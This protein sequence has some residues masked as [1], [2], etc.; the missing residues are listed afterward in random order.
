M[1]YDNLIKSWHKKAQAEDDY[2]IKFVFEYLAFI[3]YLNKTN[4]DN[5]T[6]RKL[7]Q[8]LKRSEEIKNTFIGVVDTGTIKNLIRT[9]RDRAIENVTNPDDKWWD[10]DSD[11]CPR[12]QSGDDGKIKNEKDFKNIIEFVYRARNNLFHGK[13]GPEIERD[14]IIVRHG[15]EILKPL[16]EILTGKSQ[17][18]NEATNS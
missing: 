17:V 15:F 2:F 5:K 8:E 10:C 9:L 3:A 16:M 13:K 1:N 14:F 18:Q 12:V 4:F 6:D 11:A 7:I